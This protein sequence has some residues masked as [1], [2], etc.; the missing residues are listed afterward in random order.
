M[1]S[2]P[3]FATE[4]ADNTSGPTFQTAHAYRGQKA[5]LSIQFY[6][7]KVDFCKEIAILEKKIFGLT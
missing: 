1:A 7:Q 2:C 5:R 6:L 4:F 3:R